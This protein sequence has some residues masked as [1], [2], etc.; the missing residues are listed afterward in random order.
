MNV[1]DISGTWAGE[2]SYLPTDER[3]APSDR[4]PF[5]LVA[6]PRW[7]GRFR[8]IVEDD[9]S[10][11]V[12]G[13]ATVRGRVRGSDV[14]FEKQYPVCYV[15]DQ[16][17][18]RSLREYLKSEHGIELDRDVPAPPVRYSGRYDASDEVI[19][20]T[21]RFTGEPLRFVSRGR[22]MSLDCSAGTGEWF[23]RRRSLL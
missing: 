2:Y 17:D 23:M 13:L 10:L 21:W 7:F 9:E 16:H 6:S 4:V 3:P 5:T 12:P 8:G 19:R 20:G 22:F 18:R 11:G 14:Y 15:G 1:L